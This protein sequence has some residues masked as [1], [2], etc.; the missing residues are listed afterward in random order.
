[1]Y[2]LEDRILL[3]REW[4]S[5]QHLE[6]P[7]P[8]LR[9]CVVI[10]AN[11]E[12]NLIRTL[13]SLF[14]ASQQVDKKL[15]VIVVL[16]KGINNEP[17]KAPFGPQQFY[18]LRELDIVRNYNGMRVFTL[19]LD[20]L[21]GKYAGVGLVRRIGMDLAST[22]VGRDKPIFALDGDCLI[23]E[24]YFL[25]ALDYF[26]ST[27][28]TDLTHFQFVHQE[29]T[30][31]R[32]GCS[33]VVLYELHL[34]C[35]KLALAWAGHPHSVYTIG[36]SFAVRAEAYQM[37]GGMNRR[38]AGEDFYFIQKYVERGTYRFLPEVTVYPSGRISE[39][40]PFGTGK[41]IKDL[42]GGHP[43]LTYHWDSYRIVQDFLSGMEEW[44]RSGLDLTRLDHR[45]KEFLKKER[46]ESNW[47]EALEHSTSFDSFQKRFFKWFNAFRAMKCLHYLRD[48]GLENRP[49]LEV[50][51]AICEELDIEID[52]DALKQLRIIRA[53]EGE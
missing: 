43:Q 19:L 7:D 16:N 29:T 33:P 50:V 2:S 4:I 26:S 9:A 11:N 36:S 52:A 39:R 21:P 13:Q 37:S 27:L 23:S 34:R 30:E 42:K 49:V 3:H 1:M 35:Y 51:H 38:K 18:K 12:P 31:G 53:F 44:Y 28:E 32:S 45:L 46:I 10:P 5:K 22:R 17:Y 14:K 41:A 24:N 8:A 40:V 15:E 20:N 25:R 48:H 47:L 6:D